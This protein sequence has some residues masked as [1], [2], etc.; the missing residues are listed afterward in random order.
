MRPLLHYCSH[1]FYVSIELLGAAILL[2]DCFSALG[3]MLKIIQ[4]A[5]CRYA[6]ERRIS[7]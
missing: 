7:A 6:Y 5:M 2:R 4:S 1:L 3:G